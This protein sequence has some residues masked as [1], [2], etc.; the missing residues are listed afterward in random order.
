MNTKFYRTKLL[1]ITENCPIL[2]NQ[3]KNILG[4]NT[5]KAITY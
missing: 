5:I 4:I 3:V 1:N 2:N